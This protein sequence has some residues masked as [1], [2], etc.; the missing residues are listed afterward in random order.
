[1]R[2]TE[3][4]LLVFLQDRAGLDASFD[5][6]GDLLAGGVLDSLLLIELVLYIER[7]FGVVLNSNDV[8]PANFRT[9]ETL[10]A[11]I[12]QRLDSSQRRVA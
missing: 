5:A 3:T 1:M 9:I 12:D 4:E 2:Q 11:V 7:A 6:R 8:A 10:A